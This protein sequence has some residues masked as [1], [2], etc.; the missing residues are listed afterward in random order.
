MLVHFAQSQVYFEHWKQSHVVPREYQLYMIWKG[1]ICLNK[2]A[3]GAH[4]R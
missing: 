3:S 2:E 4:L 1:V